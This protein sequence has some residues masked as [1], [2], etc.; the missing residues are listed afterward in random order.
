MTR[1]STYDFGS[2][3]CSEAPAAAAVGKW[4]GSVQ[5]LPEADCLRTRDCKPAA[6]TGLPAHRCDHGCA[7][8]CEG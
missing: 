5:G 3:L 1:L 8:D 7:L 6:V 2:A 4:T